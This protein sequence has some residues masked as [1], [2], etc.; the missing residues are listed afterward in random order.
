MIRHGDSTRRFVDDGSTVTRTAA[1][2]PSGDLEAALAAASGGRSATEAVGPA[3]ELLVGLVQARRDVVVRSDV[4]VRGDLVVRGAL[5]DEDA[6]TPSHVDGPA[7]DHA[8]GPV[9]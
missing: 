3:P 9:R 4:V 1:A 2:D 5:V 8:T 7:F 6:P